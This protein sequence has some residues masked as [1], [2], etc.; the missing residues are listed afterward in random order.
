MPDERLSDDVP[1][2]PVYSFWGWFALTTGDTRFDRLLVPVLLM[3]QAV[4]TGIFLLL[5]NWR[6][7]STSIIGAALLV[8]C[9][10]VAPV[11]RV[12]LRR[13]FTRSHTFYLTTFWVY[14]L[15]WQR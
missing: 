8:L 15:I 14:S 1:P 10:G 5:G 4:F 11:Q 3:I 6:I 9:A 2:E 13:K 7:A 12:I